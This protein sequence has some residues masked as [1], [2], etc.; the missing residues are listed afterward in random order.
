MSCK[1]GFRKFVLCN[2]R[3]IS[4]LPSEKCLLQPSCRVNKQ[5]LTS[6]DSLARTLIALGAF[7]P[8]VVHLPSENLT[9]PYFSGPRGVAISVPFP[10]VRNRKGTESGLFN[11]SRANLTVRITLKNGDPSGAGKIWENQ[12]FT[13][14][15]DQHGAKYTQIDVQTCQGSSRTCRIFFYVHF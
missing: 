9:L 7:C 11:S 14:K 8:M 15:M 4:R 10:E 12:F 1:K 6:F 2:F 5:V 13:G 3:Q